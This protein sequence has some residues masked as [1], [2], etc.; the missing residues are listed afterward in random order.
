[1]TDTVVDVGT[2]AVVE[3]DLAHVRAY[4]PLTVS[5]VASDS[6]GVGGCGAWL[7]VRRQHLVTLRQYASAVRLQ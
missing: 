5:T 2:G 3:S 6:D 1:M 7:P 4:L